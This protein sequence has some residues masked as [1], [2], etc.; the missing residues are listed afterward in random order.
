MQEVSH[1]E[2]ALRKKLRAGNLNFVIVHISFTV[3][4]F[5]FLALIFLEPVIQKENLKLFVD[6][7]CGSFFLQLEPQVS[8]GVQ[9]LVQESKRETLCTIQL[10]ITQQ[11]YIL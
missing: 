10:I 1:R 8:M 5:L 3:Y 7:Y 11:S 9:L 6:P 2:L 4:I